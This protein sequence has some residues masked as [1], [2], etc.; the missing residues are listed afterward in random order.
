MVTVE[1]DENVICTVPAARIA[2]KSSIEAT[3]P[4]K[5]IPSEPKSIA[6]A[7]VR[8][9][10]L[11][12]ISSPEGDGYVRGLIEAIREYQH[13]ILCVGVGYV[14]RRTYL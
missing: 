13:K 9:R 1:D 4:S 2:V 14:D 11:V 6:L 7:K 3:F 8:L 12:L 5:G 10:Q